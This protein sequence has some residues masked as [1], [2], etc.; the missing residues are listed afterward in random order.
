MF[1]KDHCILLPFIPYVFRVMFCYVV[2]LKAEKDYSRDQY[3]HYCFKLQ[4][5]EFLR[6]LARKI[7]LYSKYSIAFF[8]FRFLL[9]EVRCLFDA[10]FRRCLLR[11]KCSKSWLNKLATIHRICRAVPIHIFYILSFSQRK[12]SNISGTTASIHLKF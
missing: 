8:H 2:T 9:V 1:F 7:M 3:E 4:I 10:V 5:M 11:L 6:N 12:R